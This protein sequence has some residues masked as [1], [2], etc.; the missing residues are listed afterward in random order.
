LSYADDNIIEVTPDG[1]IVNAWEIDDEIGSNDCWHLPQ[2]FLARGDTI[3]TNNI[4]SVIDIAFIKMSGD[5]IYTLVTAAYDDNLVYEVKL[6]RTGAWWTP[7]SW[8]MNNIHRVPLWAEDNDN[9][10]IDIMGDNVIHSSWDT[11]GV[12]ITDLNMAFLDTIAADDRSDGDYHSGVCFMNETEPLQ[13][14]TT[15]FTEDST[16]VFLASNYNNPPEISDITDQNSYVNAMIGPIDFTID[17]VESDPS[18]LIVSATSDDQI[19]VP[20]S[21]ITLGGSDENRTIS[22]TPAADESGSA[23]ITVTVEDEGG[24]TASD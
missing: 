23:L 4:D 21:N 6:V 18:I 10:G 2:K 15:D 17:D 1:T 24:E 12:V 22:I 13:F 11:T 9:L 14:A 16:Q 5:T 8:G 3:E 7:N 19:V 20:D